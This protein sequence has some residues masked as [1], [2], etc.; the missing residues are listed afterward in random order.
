MF[1]SGH[2][3]DNFKFQIKHYGLTT[4]AE[5]NEFQR[6]SK[7]SSKS[8]KNLSDC[9][10]GCRSATP[11]SKTGNK[12]GVFHIEDYTAKMEFMLCS[13]DYVKFNNYLEPGR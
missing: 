8:R 4:I 13:E 12:F 7:S 1:L 11:S 9:R 2:P 6:S 3:L 5:F 10:L